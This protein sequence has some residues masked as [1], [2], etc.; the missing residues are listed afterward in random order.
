MQ[1]FSIKSQKFRA[2]DIEA[3]ETR[4]SQFQKEVNRLKKDIQ[5][6]SIWQFMYEAMQDLDITELLSSDRGSPLVLK[7]TAPT[8]V[9]LA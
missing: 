3:V 4:A 5:F 1:G 9:Q 7:K 6:W 8:E 2:L